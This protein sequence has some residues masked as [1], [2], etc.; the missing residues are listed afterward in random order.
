MW[1]KKIAPAASPVRELDFATLW[2]CTAE[3]W[4]CAGGDIVVLRVTGEIDLLSYPLCT[5]PCM[6]HWTTP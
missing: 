6:P 1:A 4:T 2:S 3:S 5:P